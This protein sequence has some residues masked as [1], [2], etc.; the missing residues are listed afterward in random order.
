MDSLSGFMVFIRVAEAR[1]F[2]AA[3]QSLGISA[4]AVGKRV[5]R[6]EERLGCA[7][8]TAARAASP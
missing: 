7:C 5:A 4:S 3:G 1:S 6:L 8:S 2:V